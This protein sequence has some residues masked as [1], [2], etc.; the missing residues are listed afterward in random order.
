[1]LLIDRKTGERIR[2]DL[3]DGRQIVITICA[4]S[5]SREP[6]TGN[7]RGH[8]KVGIDAPAAFKISRDPT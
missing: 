3:G 6:L 4:T 1:M 5:T 8:A 7:P 2:I